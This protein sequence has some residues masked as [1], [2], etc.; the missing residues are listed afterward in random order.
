MAL[1]SPVTN[2]VTNRL[3]RQ[4]ARWLGK[5]FR[6]PSSSSDGAA[7]GVGKN[8]FSS[9]NL[10]AA[11]ANQNKIL[12]RAFEFVIGKSVLPSMSSESLFL[13]YAPHCPAWSPVSLIWGG[14][15]DELRSVAIENRSKKPKEKEVILLGMGYFTWSGGAWNKAPFFLVAN[16]RTR[17]GMD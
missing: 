1:Q 9:Q 5:T 7:I 16:K 10:D 17:K 2:F 14:M 4:G 15:V 13:R 8:R 12:D 3:F 6:N 11:S